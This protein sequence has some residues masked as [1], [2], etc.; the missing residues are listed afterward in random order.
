MTIYIFPQVQWES[1]LPYSSLPYA[2][3]AYLLWST[4]DKREYTSVLQKPHQIHRE[5]L[6][7]GRTI[8]LQF[9]PGGRKPH[10]MSEST[11]WR[12]HLLEKTSPKRLNSIGK[13]LTDTV[14]QPLHHLVPPNSKDRFL[15][16]YIT[17]KEST[18]AW[19]DLHTNWCPERLPGVEAHDREGDSFSKMTE[20]GLYTFFLLLLLIS[21]SL[22]FL[23]RQWS[24]PYSSIYY[25]RGEPFWLLDPSP[26]TLI[27][28]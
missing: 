12:F 16:S 5:Q 9:S 3:R 15:D 23:E 27:C 26:K 21:L 18:K 17:F 4:A 10:Q 2:P 13:A 1:N 11:A 24:Y 6:Y 28:S 22:S 8:F 20:P 7:F 19:L 14:N 25:K